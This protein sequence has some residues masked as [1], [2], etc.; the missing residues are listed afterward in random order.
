MHSQHPHNTRFESQTE[1]FMNKQLTSEIMGGNNNIRL[2]EMEENLKDLH[3]RVEKLKNRSKGQG[4]VHTLRSN[5]LL[6]R[7]LWDETHA[8]NGR[9]NSSI[10]EIVQHETFQRKSI[11]S[12]IMHNFYFHG[13]KEEKSSILHDHHHQNE[14]K[15][16]YLCGMESQ[17]SK[18]IN[19]TSSIFVLIHGTG[20][21]AWCWYKLIIHL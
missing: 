19:M 6:G 5:I 12:D 8:N 11:S 13:N 2:Q 1:V 16:E 21:G 7:M 18:T 10:E 17:A 14:G 9:R 4:K 15:Q 3:G 20:H